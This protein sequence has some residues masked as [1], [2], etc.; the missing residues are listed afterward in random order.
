MPLHSAK[1]LNAQQLISKPRRQKGSGGQHF[2]RWEES[3]TSKALLAAH[4]QFGTALST[5]GH[6]F[7]GQVY[8]GRFPTCRN[9]QTVSDLN[10]NKK[11]N[12]KKTIIKLLERL[13][14]IVVEE[15]CVESKQREKMA[16]TLFCS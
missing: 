11:N 5:Y 8:M 16:G 14:S 1:G 15:N 3:H 10:K 9:K 6:K 4:R 2:R 7:N 12:N 13:F